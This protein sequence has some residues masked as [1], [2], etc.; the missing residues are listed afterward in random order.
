MTTGQYAGVGA[1]REPHGHAHYRINHYGKQVV[2][3]PTRC[4]S[5]QHDLAHVGYAASEQAQILRVSCK[6]CSDIPRPDHAWALRTG[7]RHADSAEFDDT[8]YS[9]LLRSP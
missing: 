8:P 5:D 1:A 3:L 9:G 2:V 4:P 6:A 7:G